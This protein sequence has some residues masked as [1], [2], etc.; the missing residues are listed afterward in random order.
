MHFFSYSVHWTR[1]YFQR[2]DAA[3]LLTEKSISV[4]TME[5]KLI[6]VRDHGKVIP[7]DSAGIMVES[8]NNHRSSGTP[9]NVND[10]QKTSTTAASVTERGTQAACPG[11]DTEKRSHPIFEGRK[12]AVTSA[13]RVH[14]IGRVLKW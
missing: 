12:F 11:G 13:T 14:R 4:R 5:R 8:G 7:I 6:C 2:Q 10:Y 3:T 9:L 1:F